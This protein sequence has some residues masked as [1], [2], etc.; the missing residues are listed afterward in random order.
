M[1]FFFVF[2]TILSHL[3]AVVDVVHFLFASLFLVDKITMCS[4]EMQALKHPAVSGG[5]DF[6]CGARSLEI[7]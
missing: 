4:S 6:W 5:N 1:F 2:H 7:Y 3:F